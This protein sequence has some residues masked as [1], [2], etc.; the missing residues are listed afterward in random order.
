MKHIILIGFMGAGKSSVGKRLAS[1]LHLEFVDTDELIVKKQKRPVSEIFASEGEAFFRSL[2][3][4]TLKEL[5][6]KEERL[7]IAVGGGL[8]MTPANQPLLK[9]LGEVVYLKAEVDTLMERLKRDTSR[10]LLQGGDLRTK[11]TGLMQQREATY[12]KIA[13]FTIWTDHKAF[14]ALILE[15]SEK[16]S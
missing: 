9:Q 14:S 13:D 2:E 1:H 8:P 12:E 6:K 7:V 11:I 10:P 4:E 3:T 5:L 15:I 16:I